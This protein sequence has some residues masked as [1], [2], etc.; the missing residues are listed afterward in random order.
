[1]VKISTLLFTPW[2]VTLR[3]IQDAR[4]TEPQCGIIFKE[5]APSEAVALLMHLQKSL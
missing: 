2:N 5:A 3:K 4:G 1:M